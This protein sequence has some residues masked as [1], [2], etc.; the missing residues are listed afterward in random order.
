MPDEHL[1]AFVTARAAM[2]D[3]P[4]A[5]DLEFPTWTAATVRASEESLALRNREMRVTVA[6]RAD[7][8]I[9]AF[10]ELRVSQ[11]FDTWLHG[12]HR[13]GRRRTA[14]RGWRGP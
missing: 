3:A 2:D 6:I 12:R 8:E 1:A 13:H 9:G 10:T 5:D 14:G 7:G 11:R 4:S